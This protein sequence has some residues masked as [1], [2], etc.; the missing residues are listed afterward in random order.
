MPSEQLGQAID[1]QGA[2]TSFGATRVATVTVVS[3]HK[4]LPLAVKS[5]GQLILQTFKA[6]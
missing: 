5:T 6:R 4:Q 2:W 1:D 3:F